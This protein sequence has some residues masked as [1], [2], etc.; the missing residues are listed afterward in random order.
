MSQQ[1]T[2][3]IFSITEGEHLL[4]KRL[5]TRDGRTMSRQL[6]YIIKDYAKRQVAQPDTARLNDLTQ[7][8]ED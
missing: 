6:A 7:T 8:L 3:Y 5:A 1:M 2:R 4:L